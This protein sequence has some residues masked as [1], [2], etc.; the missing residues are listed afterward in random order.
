VALVEPVSM[1][2]TVVA[3]WRGVGWVGRAGIVIAIH[4]VRPGHR[5]TRQKSNR[6]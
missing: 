2:L 6:R 5:R 1:A 3:I 4:S